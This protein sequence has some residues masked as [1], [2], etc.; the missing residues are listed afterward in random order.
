MCFVFYKQKMTVVLGERED[1]E[2]EQAQERVIHGQ[3]NERNEQRYKKKYEKRHTSV[4]PN[5][6][7]I[8]ISVTLLS[9]RRRLLLSGIRNYRVSNYEDMVRN[10]DSGVKRTL[11]FEQ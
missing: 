8:S 6:I 4:L 2:V 11:N 7:Q 10:F 1:R 9:L 3:R 5:L